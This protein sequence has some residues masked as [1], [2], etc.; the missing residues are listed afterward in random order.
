VGAVR[1]ATAVRTSAQT[2]TDGQDLTQPTVNTHISDD[3]RWIVFDRPEKANA[4][5]IAD[6]RQIAG[7]V[8]DPPFASDL[9]DP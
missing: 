6:I 4:L 7:P 1:R 2:R 3:L 9:L 5:T 8:A